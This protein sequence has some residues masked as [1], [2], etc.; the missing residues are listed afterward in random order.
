M[1]ALRPSWMRSVFCRKTIPNY[2]PTMMHRRL[3]TAFFILCVSL[4]TLADAAA[5]QPV[6]L[7]TSGF[8]TTSVSGTAASSVEWATAANVTMLNSGNLTS[9]NGYNFAVLGGQSTAN[10]VAV[11][12]NLNTSGQTTTQRGFS[13]NFSVNAGFYLSK[14]T[15]KAGHVSNVGVKQAY[16]STL[17]YRIVRVSDSVAIASGSQSFDYAGTATFFDRVFTLS[18]DLATGVS[19]R[20][21][22][23]MNNIT[24]GGAF[25]IYDGVTLEAYPEPSSSP[26]FAQGL[27]F[28]RFQKPTSSFQSLSYFDDFAFD[29]I[30]SNYHSWRVG[31][32]TSTHWLEVTYPRAVTLGSAHLY[33]GVILAATTQV[34][35]SFR[36]QYHN[37]TSWIDIPGSIVTGNTL[38]ERNVL[39]TSPVTASRFRLQGNENVNNR[40]VRELA[41]FPPNPNGSNVEQGYP[42]GTDVDLNLA[43]QR[44]ATA[45]SINS[46]NYAIKAVDGYVDDASRWLCDNVTSGQTLEVDLLVDH[47]ISSAHLHSG[48]YGAAT[49]P[50]TDFSLE[51]WDATNSVWVPIPGAAITGNTDLARVITFSSTVV[52]SRVRLVISGAAFGRVAELQI[53]GP[54][55][56]G[57]PVG[58]DIRYEAPPTA[59]WDDFS[60]SSY[61]IRI[62]PTPD[63]RLGLINGSAIFTDNNAGAAALDWQ[64][65]LNHRDGSYRIR[66]LSTGLCLGLA[67]ISTAANTAVIG[68]TYTG[69][70]HQNWFLEVV[71]PTRFRLL[72]GYSGLAIQSLGGN[73]TL[74]TQLVVT[75]PSA[76]RLQQWDAQV[77]T[78][79][80]KK[81]IA[82]T[83]SLPDPT[84]TDPLATW[85]SH[86]Y[87]N[88]KST[89][90]SYTWGRQTSDTFPSLSNDHTHNPMSWGNF[91]FVH[92]SNA[93]DGIAATIESNRRDLLSNPK[94]AYWLGFNEPDRTDQSNM[95]VATAIQRWPRLLAMNAPLLAPVAGTTDTTQGWQ[96]DFYT[97]AEAQGYRVDYTGVH[98]YAGPNADSLI[99]LLQDVY[100][101]WQRPVWLTEFST[102]RWS[103]SATW[104]D[105]DNFNFLAEFM[106]RAESLPWL[107]RY[108]LFNFREDPNGSPANPIDPTAAPRSNSIRSDGT[109]TAFGE[110]YAGWDGVTSVV[111][112]KSYHLHNKQEYRRV[113]NPVSTD[114]VASVSPET[115]AL[116]NQWFLI[117]GT[118]A[119]TVRI[120]SNRDGRRLRYF[121]G[122]YVGMVAATNFTGQSEWLLESDQY[123]WYFLKHPQSSTRLRMNSSGTPVNGSV[124]GTTDD[125]KWRFVVPAV[126]DPIAPDAPVVTAQ[127]GIKQITLSWPAVATAT[128]YAIE[129][130][131]SIGQTW[132]SMA[133]GITQTT[134]INTGLLAATSYSYRVSA[135]NVLGT[136]APSSTATA[137]TQNAL[138]SLAAW[139]AEYLSALPL[140]QQAATADPNNNGIPNL[141][142][143]AYS[144]NPTSQSTSASPFIIRPSGTSSMEIEFIWNWRAAD[145]T[146]QLRSG[147]DLTTSATWPIVTPTTTQTTREGDIDRLRL[148]LPTS[149]NPRRFYL[150][151]VNSN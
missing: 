3:K 20:L 113:Q 88:Y 37:G 9:L 76:S 136:S 134:W 25:A 79:H 86:F 87:A 26:A 48:F 91:G 94:P 105:A 78:Y 115:T 1:D 18:G 30:V 112:N 144:R 32:N 117:P 128:S 139:Q 121:T 5:T 104:S 116:G 80:P 63:R 89:A 50:L 59:A 101:K 16:V 102:V 150:L 24:S 22:V 82:A 13:V 149:G 43:Y 124:T 56:G 60:D 33:S 40:T 147:T 107:K 114:L 142:E 27:N 99:S 151:Q 31:S 61:R 72:N 19:Y 146:W 34:W 110:L 36:F 15:V 2:L 47:A 7:F 23:G 148:T 95:T 125:Y 111:N 97:Q 98:W 100:N 143:Y 4:L 8:E 53:F 140:A 74:G 44:P 92:D 130:F 73:Q 38:P 52:T 90:W 21:E 41:M 137:T 131:D 96:V 126:S 67:S 58:Q 49:T 118:T 120:V 141:L 83:T 135:S 122:T 17:N 64:L 123:G 93:S 70:P 69:M 119:N 28:A 145:L 12:S 6:N 109:L 54:R 85:F 45:S 66:H 103:G 75:T 127:G 10:N 129:R 68:E 46:T 133:T 55:T 14:L 132:Q 35:Q 29:G 77:Q 71:S 42:I 106:W 39:F 81:G 57:V 84:F 65:L 108:S 51:S 62:Q 11:N 138:A